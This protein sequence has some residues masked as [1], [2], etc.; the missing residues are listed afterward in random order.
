MTLRLRVSPVNVIE[1]DEVPKGEF[2]RVLILEY[3]LGAIQKVCHRPRG[4]GG[5]RKIVTKSDKGGRGSSQ[6]VMSPLQ[7]ILFQQLH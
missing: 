7:K 6:M 1:P 4:R 3:S 2:D 5:S